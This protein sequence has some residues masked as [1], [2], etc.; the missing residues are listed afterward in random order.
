MY[1]YTH[2]HIT[3]A[4]VLSCRVHRVVKERKAIKEERGLQQMQ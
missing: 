3:I 4:A 2:T 1:T